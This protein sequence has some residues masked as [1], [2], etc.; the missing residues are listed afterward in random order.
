MKRKTKDK[1]YSYTILI[2]LSLGLFVVLFPF[3]WMFSTAFKSTGKAFTFSLIPD[4]LNFANFEKVLAGENLIHEPEYVPYYDEITDKVYFPSQSDVPLSI[5]ADFTHNRIEKMK[6]NGKV[7]EY[8]QRLSNG[9]YDYSFHKAP[10]LFEYKVSGGE[11]ERVKFTS[12]LKGS[13]VYIVGN[14]TAWK[15]KKLR[16]KDGEH[17]NFMYVEPGEYQYYFTTEIPQSR[18]LTFSKNGKFLKLDNLGIVPIVKGQEVEVYYEGDTNKKVYYV[19]NLNNWKISEEQEALRINQYNNLHKAIL[20]LDKEIYVNFFEVDDISQL[21]DVDIKKNCYHYIIDEE[22]IR[23]GKNDFWHEFKKVFTTTGNFARYFFNSFIVAFFAASLTT[24]ICSF[25]GYVFAKKQFYGKDI[26]FKLL[27]AGMMVPGMMFMVPQYALVYKIGSIEFL[28]IGKILSSLQI[29]GMNTYGAMV[30]PHLA[31]VFGLFMIKQFMETIP[32]SLLEAAKIDGASESK[33]FYRI[34]VPVSA[35][36]I[37]T[38][39]LLTF[40]G[41]WSNFL[42]QLI[43]STSSN[44]YTLPVGLA[45]FQGQYSSE[46]TKLM[47]ASTITVVPI[48]ILFIFAQ[49][50]FIEGMTKGAVKG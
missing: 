14:M 18:K 10:E 8:S 9:K 23:I 40:I 48:I 47:A 2:L 6:K 15:P 7:W 11:K 1:I 25:S 37:M 17:Y 4:K 26:L 32:T 44:M 27:L 43:I 30:I 33:I 21:K 22:K 16:E 3:A 46:W 45:M 5:V 20:P 36:I 38:L 49:R 31:N 34:M 24:F 50:Y 12:S 29:M 39:F 35:P 41:Q 28:N 13:T 19:S 42:W